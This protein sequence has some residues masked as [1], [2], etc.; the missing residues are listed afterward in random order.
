MFFLL[1]CE[2]TMNFESIRDASSMKWMI[3]WNKIP[4]WMKLSRKY[5]KTKRNQT[6]NFVHAFKSFVNTCWTQSARG[7]NLLCR[8]QLKVN[9]VKCGKRFEGT[10]VDCR[11]Q[12][13]IL[14][15]RLDFQLSADDLRVNTL[16]N[17]ESINC[18]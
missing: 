6:S 14:K 10:C 16:H 11:S 8:E 15:L 17:I 2:Q 3:Y 4:K 1:S 18:H 7:N 9:F 5:A 13:I 12:S